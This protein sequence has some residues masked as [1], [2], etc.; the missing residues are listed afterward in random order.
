MTNSTV[1]GLR[2]KVGRRSACQ[3]TSFL[4]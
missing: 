1:Q 2:R 4:D 3:W